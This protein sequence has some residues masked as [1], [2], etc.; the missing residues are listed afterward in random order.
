MEGE[1]DTIRPGRWP[2]TTAALLIVFGALIGAI[3]VLLL[4]DDATSPK[5]RLA[6]VLTVVAS[7]WLMVIG[8]AHVVEPLQ[9]IGATIS[10][11][12]SFVGLGVLCVLDWRW[13]V[14]NWGVRA[15]LYAVLVGTLLMSIRLLRR[16]IAQVREFYRDEEAPTG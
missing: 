10:A 6:A 5:D 15:V 2:R 3:G 14:F 1:F 7:L 12:L 11:L 16:D 4:I 9:T 8:L 13:G